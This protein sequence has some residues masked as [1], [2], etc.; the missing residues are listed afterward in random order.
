MSIHN[1]SVLETSYNRHVLYCRRAQNRPRTRVR[2]CRPC[3]IAKAKCSFHP[4]CSRCI[5]KGLE[6]VYDTATATR[7]NQVVDEQLAQINTPNFSPI[8]LTSGIFTS[9]DLFPSGDATD[10]DAQVDIDWDG[11]V[12]PTA[13]ILPQTRKSNLCHFYQ[14]ATDI[15][16]NGPHLLAEFDA[17]HAVEPLYENFEPGSRSHTEFPWYAGSTR[18]DRLAVLARPTHLSDRT[19]ADMLSRLPISD[20]VLHVTTTVLMQMLRA[21]P[22]MM[23]RRET[24]PP[25]IHGH[26]Y[27]PSS[28]TELSLPEPLVNCIGIAQIF[29]SHN[30]ESKPFLWR[31]IKQEQRSL[32]EKV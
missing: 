4:R 16:P 31:T 25:F 24:L 32:V 28:A 2:S 10:T 9:D 12:S 22:Q 26:W 23:L 1:H 3:S 29:A 17:R 21:F 5:N 14:P 15:I 7:K 6:C 18:D 27:R 20:P 19:D 8:S 13:D 11:L 30:S